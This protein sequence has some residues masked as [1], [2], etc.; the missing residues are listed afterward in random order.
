VKEG[1]SVYVLEFDND[2]IKIG[3][4]SNVRRRIRY[5]SG[6]SRV[7]R[8][9]ASNRVSREWAREVERLAHS[10]FEDNRESGEYFSGI[11]LED[12][13]KFVNNFIPSPD[14]VIENW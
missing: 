6:A 3:I 13:I 11:G 12:G 14:S 5:L 2:I 7:T 1:T 8:Y 10:Y 9:W 4:S